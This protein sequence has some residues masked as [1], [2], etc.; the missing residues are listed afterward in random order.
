[1]NLHSKNCN[2]LNITLVRHRLDVGLMVLNRIVAV[3]YHFG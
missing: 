1:M 3:L 2:I